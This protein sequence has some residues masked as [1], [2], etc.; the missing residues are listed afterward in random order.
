MM[1]DEGSNESSLPEVKNKFLQ[2]FTGQIFPKK[3]M[4]QFFFS[5]K[6]QTGGGGG[7]RRGGFVNRA[8]FFPGFFSRTPSLTQQS[9]IQ[10]MLHAK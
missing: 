5:E 4:G 8:Q 9:H 6:G 10:F 1:I 7:V 3:I 2:L